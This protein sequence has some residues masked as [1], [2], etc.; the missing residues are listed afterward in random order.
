MKD[1]VTQKLVTTSRQEME[2]RGGVT[3]IQ[4]CEEE[5]D[6]RGCWEQSWGDGG[7]A[8]VIGMVDRIWILAGI[9]GRETYKR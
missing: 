4:E 1:E 7:E 6:R 9:T 2:G 5:P 8:S 3:R